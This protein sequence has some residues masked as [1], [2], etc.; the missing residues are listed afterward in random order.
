MLVPS[1]GRPVAAG[2][3]GGTAMK[4]PRAI[5]LAVASVALVAVGTGAVLAS[6]VPGSPS[7]ATAAD[8]PAAPS[9][10]PATPTAPRLRAVLD[11]LVAKGTITAAQEAAIIDAWVSRRGDLRAERQQLRAFLA[12]GVLTSSELA[13]LPADSPLQQLKPLM[14]NGQITVQQMRQLGRGI[15]RDLRLGGGLRGGGLGAPASPAPSPSAAG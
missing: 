13:Q 2:H 15:L 4:I 12:D 8:P 3:L 1:T 9:S 7:A 14:V 10:S 5:A 11:P 6:G